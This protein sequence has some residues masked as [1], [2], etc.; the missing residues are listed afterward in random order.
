MRRFLPSLS[1]L[2]AFDAA[3]RH[4]SFTRAAEDLH[5]T[6]SGISRQINT[7]ETYLGIRLFQRV[8][9]RLVLTEIGRSY[10]EEVQN[11]LDGLE[12]IS[13]DAVRGRKLNAALRVGA[14][15]S[16]A[17]RWLLPRLSGFCEAHPELPLELVESDLTDNLAENGLDAAILR[18][19]G[20]WSGARVVELF[21]ETLVVVAAPRLAATLDLSGPMNFA[22]M[23]T[24]QNASR[25]SLWLS[26]LRLTKREH[27][28]SIQGLRLAQTGLVIRAAEA[29]LGLALVPRALV[30]AEL[31]GGSLVECFGPEVASG[32]SYW[33]LVPDEKAELPHMRLLREWM[34]TARVN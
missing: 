9:S 18:G 19:R 6:Q 24:L 32:E 34:A 17:G 14:E 8:G 3:A 11:A 7:L 5:L 31:G 33:L 29:G 22:T 1:A 28:G 23:P 12:E 21:A 13:I 25:P 30:E 10:A 16:L 26:W 15:A 2:Q 27:N 20:N 4:M